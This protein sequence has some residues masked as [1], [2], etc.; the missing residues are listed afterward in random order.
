MEEI[1]TWADKMFPVHLPDYGLVEEL[2]EAVHC[3]LK[4]AQKIRG[5]DKDEV[6]IAGLKD[7]FADLMVY[8][9]HLCYMYKVALSFDSYKSWLS[10]KMSDRTALCLMLRQVT[11]LVE[12]SEIA[13]VSD[14]NPLFRVP[15]Q[16][17]CN[18]AIIWGKQLGIDVIQ[19]TRDEWEKNVSKRD[20]S[21][22]RE[23]ADKDVQKA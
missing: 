16:V 15:A 4:R 11:L 12:Y 13:N 23:S 19:A 20:W 21:V 1:G 18:V 2:G 5:F 14:N 3:I 17:L 6:Y 22:N 7:A 9:L 8:L 10:E